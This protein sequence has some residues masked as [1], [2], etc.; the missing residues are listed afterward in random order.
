MPVQ[1]SAV[2]EILRSAE[3]IAVVG[4][5]PNPDRPSHSVARYLQREGYTIVPVRP[6][7][8]TPILGQPVYPDLVTAARTGAIDIVAVF[9]R[10]SALPDLVDAVITV[11]PRLFWTQLGVIHEE[12]A[13]RIEAAGIPVVMDHCLAVEHQ[14]LLR[15]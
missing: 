2:V 6:D 9:R 10:S 13:R 8:T 4:L 14:N 1:P 11:A 12:S 7:T 15:T 5:S 3:R